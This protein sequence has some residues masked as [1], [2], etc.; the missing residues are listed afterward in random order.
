MLF[1]STEAV[2]KLKHQLAVRDLCEAAGVKADRALIETLEELPLDKA[3]KLIEREKA[4]PA[5]T[6]RSS[7][8]S[9]SGGN[10][11]P[12]EDVKS[13]VAAIAD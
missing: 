10:S 7:G 1:R 9:G 3:R 6:P 11:K 12:A 4:R 5:S 8:F 2:K 13:F